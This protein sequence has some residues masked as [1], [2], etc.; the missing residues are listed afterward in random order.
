MPKS[1][2]L[3]PPVDKQEEEPLQT[4]FEKNKQYLTSK[5]VGLQS[6]IRRFAQDNWFEKVRF[7]AKKHW[8]QLSLGFGSIAFASLM[9]FALILSYL[10]GVPGVPGSK[11]INVS[12]AEISIDASKKDSLGVAG[13][14][15][16]VIK[17]EKDV[18]QKTIS[19]GLSVEPKFDYTIEQIN[20]R[21]FK[22]KPKSNL[23]PKQIYKFKF[24][25][26][27]NE[28]SKDLSWAFQIKD[29][30]RVL[31]TLPSNISTLVPLDSGIEIEF[32][33]TEYQDPG[34]LFQITPKTEGSFERNGKRLIFK[35]KSLKQA[36]LYTVNLK[37]VLKVK[38]S[39]KK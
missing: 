9:I 4:L 1:S 7:F 34:E 13:D 29:E 35:P 20:P 17:T 33:T 8:S 14:S 5:S 36:T 15:D 3:I 26:Q 25:S 32:N 22:I 11:P 6:S 10:P 39:A 12:A 19:Q 16:Y 30:F 38:N 21:E 28:I 31:Q 27:S 18:D 24:V 37:A 2:K 23:D